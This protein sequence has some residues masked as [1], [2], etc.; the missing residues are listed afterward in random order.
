MVRRLSNEVRVAFSFAFRAA[1]A[2][3]GGMSRRSDRF[4]LRFGPFFLD[5]RTPRW[6][7]GSMECSSVEI[8]LSSCE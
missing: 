7:D 3:N 4:K 2:R 1:V 8:T 5:G 6:C